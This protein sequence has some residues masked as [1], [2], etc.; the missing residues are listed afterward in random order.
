MPETLPTLP[1]KA[2]LI[3]RLAAMF[4]DTL[5]LFGVLFTATL[6]PSLLLKT[7]PSVN[8][9]GD[10]VHELNPLLSGLSFQAYLLVITIAF[11]CYFW[12]RQ[13]QTLGMQAWKLQL[14]SRDRGPLSLKQC[15]LRTFYA[16][17]SIACFGLGYWWQWLDKDTLTWHDRWSNTEVLQL[18]NN[19]DKIQPSK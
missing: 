15:L 10:V 3:K 5:L 19:K 17:V 13:G 18:A 1:P 12:L 6:I 16:S 7:A 9:N 2:S 14:V 4:Y 11:F 8:Q